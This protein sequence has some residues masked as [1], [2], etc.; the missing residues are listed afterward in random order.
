MKFGSLGPLGRKER[1]RAT[2]Q[3]Y[4]LEPTAPQL[5]WIGRREALQAQA[6]VT[7]SAFAVT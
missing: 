4:Q 2:V 3:N 6:K 1:R 7:A 5:F